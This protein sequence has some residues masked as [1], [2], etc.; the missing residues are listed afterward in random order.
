MQSS[1][2]RHLGIAVVVVMLV[3]S[4]A[5]SWSPPA[6]AAVPSGG[7]VVQVNQDATTQSQNETTIAIDPTD[8]DNLVAGS[9]T[10]ETGGGQCAAY[11]STDGGT[12]W[13]HQVL[14]NA[15]LLTLAGDPVVAFDLAGTAYYLC[16]N[17]NRD[18]AGKAV[19]HSQYVYRS[20]DGGATW[21]APILAIG[22]P[23]ANPDDKGHIAIDRHAGSPFAGNVYVANTR[24]STGEIRFARSTDGGATFAADQA[25]NDADIG[26]PANIAVGADGAVYVAWAR[27]TTGLPGNST[28]IMLDKSIDGGQTFNALSGGVDHQIQA[29]GV[30]DSFDVRA[31]PDRGNGWAVLGTHPT[32][33]NVVYAVWAQDPAGIDDSDVVFSRSVDGGNSWSVPIRVNDDVNPGGEFFSQFWP[34]LAVDPVDGE[35]DVIWYSD[36]HDPNR[37]DGTALTDVYFSSS[38]NS[39]S[40]FSPSIRL[41]PASSNPSGFFGDYVAIDARG[42]V[43]HA[44]WTDTTLGGQGDQDAATTQIGA[45]DLRIVTSDLADPAI[46]GRVLAY[47]IT[48]ANDGPADAFGVTVTDTLPAGTTYVSDTGGCVEAPA[49]T[50]TCPVGRLRA[51][52]SASFTILV[53]IDADVVYAAGAA[54]TITNSTSVSSARIDPDPLDNLATETTLVIAH[55]DLSIT[56]FGAVGPPVLLPVG[57]FATLDLAKDVHNA[58]PSG[59]TDVL[60]TATA[61]AGGGGTVTP[62]TLSQA[63]SAL[64]V[65]ETRTLHESFTVGCTAPGT[66]SFAF[67]N[68]VAPTSPATSD[69][70]PGNDAAATSV[71]IVCAIPV[72]INIKPG[73]LTNPVNLGAG[74]VIPVA[75]LTTDAG[76]YGLPLAFDALD[77]DPA[78]VRFGPADLLLAGG[79][80]AT[81]GGK[82]GI[83]DSYELD[84]KTRDRDDDAILHFAV[85][86]SGLSV[87]DGEACVLGDAIVGGVTYAFMGCDNVTITP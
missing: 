87:G 9:I 80:A 2:G 81:E 41:T 17:L 84:E 13:T 21:T 30:V 20:F 86:A 43:A 62:A 52:A 51:G 25:I 73:S 24:L 55:A 42:G 26:F 8:P 82:A 7:P 53:A 6:R 50:L 74:G 58:G 35:I 46:A 44:I 75:I 39:G 68:A 23:L 47:G 69:P 63:M 59:P 71:S 37:T 66:T 45:A 65:G 22:S 27:E 72:A 49:G 38:T 34:T 76:E 57:G 36:Q 83:R 33:P 3:S 11:H 79:G 56:G 60:A 64:A 54:V 1:L 28:A 48:V 19:Q 18:A 4:V 31:Y 77:V 85:Q 78:S 61:T 67:V 10:F 70:I 40:S 12:T 5:P 14:P 15:P 16:M 29:G 32:D